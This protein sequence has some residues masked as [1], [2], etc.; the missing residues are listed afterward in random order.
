MEHITFR[1]YF[2]RDLSVERQYYTNTTRIN[3]SIHGFRMKIVIPEGA[4]GVHMYI[5]S[6]ENT[7]TR[8]R[9]HGK[10][11]DGTT[12]LGEHIW[13]LGSGI[14]YTCTGGETLFLDFVKI[15]NPYN[16]WTSELQIDFG[17]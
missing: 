7:H 3:K 2:R 12:M 10:L 13:G 6:I 17:L 16:D 1:D 15:D 14:H 11:W 4:T 5:K 8:G 9:M